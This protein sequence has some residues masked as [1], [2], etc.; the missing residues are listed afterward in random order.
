MD[1][2][3]DP[4]SQWLGIPPGPRPV[5]HYRLL[6]VQRFESD[7]GLLHTR[8]MQR[9]AEVRKYQMG[10]QGELAL[11][12]QQEISRA[13]DVLSDPQRKAAYDLQ[14]R[15]PRPISAASP[16]AGAPPV[17]SGSSIAPPPV[18]APPP[19]HPRLVPRA[20]APGNAARH[21]ADE[22]AE[23]PLL[24]MRLLPW[25]V[26]GIALFAAVALAVQFLGGQG[27]LRVQ[28]TGPT[29][30][31]AALLDG[32]PVD[33]EQLERGRP[34]N[35]GMHK[36]Q[37]EG[38]AIEPYAKEFAVPRGETVQLQVAL[39]ALSRPTTQP[40][41]AVASSN[42]ARPPGNAEPPPQMQLPPARSAAPLHCLWKAAS[43]WG[44]TLTRTRPSPSNGAA[45]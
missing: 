8:T 15:T 7:A 20:P 38:P 2:A 9:M 19:Q 37:L 39:V 32:A 29:A 1:N 40:P 12:L 18:I 4:Y 35:M 14:L 16:S 23:P 27:T 36:L 25:F 26:G 10:P 3:F 5:D 33:L 43:G 17:E 6:G 41:P 31:V 13:F 28:F 22:P 44:T 34:L 24:V 21:A 11:R 30:G 45:S 42:D